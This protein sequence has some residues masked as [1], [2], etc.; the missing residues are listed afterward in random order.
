M[1]LGHATW[2]VYVAAG[3]IVGL[4]QCFLGYR[5]FRIVLGLT[6]FL[7]AAGFAGTMGFSLTGNEIM[8]L[9]FGILGGLIGAG[10]MVAIYFVGLFLIG[11]FLGGVLGAAVAPLFSHA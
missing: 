3:V 10:L 6:G 5:I 1:A 4:I 7:M 9:I 2:Q 8:A 11:A